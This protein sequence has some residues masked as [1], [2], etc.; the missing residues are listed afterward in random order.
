VAVV[1]ASLAV[2]LAL[3][4]ELDC[5]AEEAEELVFVVDD[6]AVAAEVVDAARS[7]VAG[8]VDFGVDACFEEELDVVWPLFGHKLGT[9]W[10]WKILP[11]RVELPTTTCEQAA[12]TPCATWA[13]PVT[14]ALEQ[15]ESFWKSSSVHDGKV[16]PYA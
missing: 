13:S 2:L 14:H 8:A 6:E 11:S 9:I 5:A 7:V 16:W 12:L 1:A 15:W 10:P 4:V 3:S